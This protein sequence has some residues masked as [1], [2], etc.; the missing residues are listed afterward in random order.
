VNCDRDHDVSRLD[1]L[2]RAQALVCHG[3][4]LV[5]IRL[6]GSK[7]PALD[8]WDEY[9][10]R[11]P[12]PEELRRWYGRS[13]PFGL[14]IVCGRVSGNLELLD[15]DHAVDVLFPEWCA[16]V[17]AEC[18]GLVAR[19]SVVRTPRAP[20]G[21]HVR[22]RCRAVTIPGNLK[23]AE[24]PYTDPETGRPKRRT[25]VETRGEGGQALA[26]GCPPECHPSGGLYVHAGGPDVTALE[27]VAAGER[28]VLLRCARSFDRVPALEPP[29]PARREAPRPGGLLLPG[30]DF[31]ARGP[32]WPDLLGPHGW[33]V[34]HGRGD[35]R[36]WRRPGK[37]GPGWSATTGYCST[38]K[39]GDLFCVFSTNA[40]P[41]PAPSG[42]RRCS[43]HSRFSAYALLEHGADLG[44]AA[45][46]LY[47][48]GYGERVARQGHGRHGTIKFSFTVRAG[49]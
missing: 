37:D 22:Y 14:G 44:A 49:A 17:E 15:F 29:P 12:V 20:N 11:L 46:A 25:L 9:Q 31:N 23:L 5:P 45:R 27:D 48:L 3:L 35:V 10:G 36:Y 7:R 1:L 43:A 40:Y 28:E 38:E 21:F 6:D 33:H 42:D 18:P 47:R 39:G 8:S 19:L 34:V 26:P 41:F 24:E 4:S 2:Q 30:D 13:R 32:D 16:L